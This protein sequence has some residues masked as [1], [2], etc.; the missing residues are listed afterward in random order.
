MNTLYYGL[1]GVAIFIGF[2]IV[3][4]YFEDQHKD[5]T[6]RLKLANRLKKQIHIDEEYRRQ[7]RIEVPITNESFASMK[8]EPAH[9]V[10]INT[11]TV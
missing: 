4:S 9:Q 10:K 5:M 6:Y 2:I 8:S 1:I 3:Y 7:L 11:H